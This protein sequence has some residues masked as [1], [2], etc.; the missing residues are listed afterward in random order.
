VIPWS[1]ASIAGHAVER[2]LAQV[3]TRRIEARVARLWPPGPHALGLAAARVAEAI[4][5]SS[6]RTQTVLTVLGGEFGV[7]N[8]VGLVPCLLGPAGIRQVR[9][10]S[11]NAREQ[12][13]VETVLGA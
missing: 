2:V 6:R 8:R 9:L 13:Q 4:V 7:R 3:Q 1:E 10:P 5:M 12:V 11:L